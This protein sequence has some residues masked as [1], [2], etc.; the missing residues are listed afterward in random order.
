MQWGNFQ[1]SIPGTTIGTEK[2]ISPQMKGR[3][4]RFE[5]KIAPEPKEIKHNDCCT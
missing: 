2:R 1:G 5:E 3:E 4:W